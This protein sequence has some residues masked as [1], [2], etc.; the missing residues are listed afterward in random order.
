[1]R[2]DREDVFSK[3]FI[4]PK[5]A[6]FDCLDNDPG[7]LRQTMIRDGEHW[8]EMGWDEVFGVMAAGLGG[9]VTAHETA[10]A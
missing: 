6:A 9:V 3:G 1:M 4:R 8:R 2:G 5:G 7:R 10:R